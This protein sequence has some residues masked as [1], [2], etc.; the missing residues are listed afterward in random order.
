MNKSVLFLSFALLLSACSTIPADSSLFKL[1]YRELMSNSALEG[2]AVDVEQFKTLEDLAS[3]RKERMLAA[4]AVAYA[5]Y[6]DQQFD[7]AV[8]RLEAFIRDYPAYPRMDYV[9]YLR[10]LAT[11]AQGKQEFN[12]AVSDISVRPAYPEKLRTAYRY[13]VDLVTRYPKSEYSAQALNFMKNI[14]TNLAAYELF[15]ARYDLLEKRFNEVVRRSQ[16]VLEFYKDTPVIAQAYELQARAYRAMG[17]PEMAE[18][19]ERRQKRAERE[20]AAGS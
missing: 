10:A 12:E 19:V 13:F 15:A 5:Y 20:A 14:R 2:A 9:L 17:K 6:K 16:Y 1:K 4:L 7:A 8:E 11:K 3:N 18:E